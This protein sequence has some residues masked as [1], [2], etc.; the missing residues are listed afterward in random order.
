MSLAGARARLA[1]VG[2]VGGKPRAE[3]LIDLAELEPLFAHRVAVVR[4]LLHEC[5]SL[6]DELGDKTL[7]GRVLLRLADI[8][9]VENDLEGV[10]QLA[11]RAR[12]RL[13][14]DLART[15]AARCL[16]ARVSIRRHDFA[17]AREKLV[18]ISNESDDV[19]P[20]TAAARRAVA[21]IAF[22]WAEL[23]MEEQQYEEALARLSA[24]AAELVNMQGDDTTE[25]RFAC[26]QARG[27]M[28]LAQDKFALACTSLREAVVLA[29]SAGAVEDELD[30]RVGLAG[31][32][33]QRGDPV[34]WDEAEK[35]LQITRDTALEHGLDG[36]YMAA[37]VGQAGLMAHKGR[38]HA[39]LDRCLEIAEVAGSKKDLPR[40]IAAVSLMSSIYER[41][42]DLASA[43][44]TFAEAHA[45]LKEQLGAGATDLIRPPLSAFAARIGQDKFA[46]IAAAVNK[47]A[48][49]RQMFRRR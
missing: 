20:E 4:P 36:Q 22:A 46:E 26:L 17:L 38:T 19:A 18:A 33:V 12:E 32:L 37:L 10:E 41:K 25:L 24:L 7:E 3:A 11:E 9:L 31:T 28:A 43:Y 48:H 35:H 13:E 30:V 2:A 21:S 27:M 47:A 8:K 44:R 45:A 6:L 29:K 5:G 39:A 49:A 40:Y 34:G 23:A 15:L 1:E 14:G 16:F 42:G